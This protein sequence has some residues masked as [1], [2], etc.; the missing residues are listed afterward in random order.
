M[1]LIESHE[2]ETLY[3]METEKIHLD[4]Q[5]IEK[6]AGTMKSRIPEK[7][8]S[9][10]GITF[11]VL[12]LGDK[13]WSSW[14]PGTQNLFGRVLD[15]LWGSAENHIQKAVL[16]RLMGHYG[17]MTDFFTV[18]PYIEAAASSEDWILR[19]FSPT[20]VRMLTK[21]DREQAQR[22]LLRLVESD[23]PY[24]R[25]L[26]SESLR[27][28]TDLSWIQKEPDYSLKVLK[29]LFTEKEEYPRSSVGNNLS[30]LA[31]KNPELV[32][33]LVRDLVAME[34]ENAYWIAH[35]AC[36]NLVKTETERVL[37][38]LGVDEYRYK[39]RVHTRH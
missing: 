1:I 14:N 3:K 15:S 7:R 39:G 2:V 30:D 34:D 28:V 18:T 31:R 8:R 11:V 19:E 16:L 20:F 5:A 22:Y 24:L 23:N 9:S 17:V 33:S 36:R 26:V 13:L 25:R 27:P 10:N 21:A 29:R 4:F 6:M 35:R 12:Q 37:D 38:L 32:F